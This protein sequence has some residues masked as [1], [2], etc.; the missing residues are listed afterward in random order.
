MN[1]HLH[2]PAADHVPQNMAKGFLLKMT[3]LFPTKKQVTTIQ[4]SE[5]LSQDFSVAVK[6]LPMSLP[7]VKKMAKRLF[8]NTIFSG[9]L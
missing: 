1:W 7:P 5:G 8:F 2:V 4:V 9:E 3:L 6:F